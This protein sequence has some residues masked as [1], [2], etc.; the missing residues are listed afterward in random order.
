[1]QRALDGNPDVLGKILMLIHLQTL[2]CQT[3]HDFANSDPLMASVFKYI[4][5]N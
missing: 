2:M 5:S 1:M 3:L 4:Y